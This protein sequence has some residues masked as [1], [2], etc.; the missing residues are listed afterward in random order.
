MQLFNDPLSFPESEVQAPASLILFHFLLFHVNI[1]AHQ[2][3][4]SSVSLNFSKIHC[5]HR[6]MLVFVLYCLPDFPLL[7]ILSLLLLFFLFCS[8][9]YFHCPDFPALLHI[10]SIIFL[11]A[12]SKR[13]SSGLIQLCFN[14]LF[15][16]SAWRLVSKEHLPRK[17]RAS[18]RKNIL[19]VEIK[20]KASAICLKTFARS[21]LLEFYWYGSISNTSRPSKFT[22]KQFTLLIIPNH[23]SKN[24]HSKN[25]MCMCHCKSCKTYVTTI[26]SFG[27]VLSYTANIN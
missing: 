20:F 21:L 16:F 18:T 13:G 23:Y 26:G 2:S 25:W 3:Q 9:E 22:T 8:F 11:I 19:S 4:N 5:H 6:K 24:K 10:L 1:E 15:S 27:T 17:A 14:S 7:S 12:S